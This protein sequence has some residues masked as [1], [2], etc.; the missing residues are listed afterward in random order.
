MIPPAV[1]TAPPR[2]RWLALARLFWVFLALAVLAIWLAALPGFYERV[3]TLTVEPFRLGERVIFDN[4]TAQAQ[5][6]QRSLSLSQTAL[7]DIGFSF[8]QIAVYILLAALIL[9]RAAN[10]FGW[11]SA[12]VLMLM[13][14]TSMTQAVGVSPPFPGALLLM[15]SPTYIVWPLWIAWLAL[16][17]NGRLV[18]RQAF[19]PFWIAVVA[20][21]GLQV[22]NVL[23]IAGFLPPRIDTL[24]ATAGPLVTLPVFGFVLLSQVYRY[25]LVSTPVE[26]QQTKWFLFGVGLFCGVLVVFA[27]TPRSFQSSVVV[28]DLLN[29]VFLLF[30][31]SVAIAILRYRLFDIDLIIRRT[32]TYAVLAAL[33]ALVY[34]GS[35]ILLQQ[36][37]ALV[38]GQRSEVITVLSTL[39]IAALFVP[40]RRRIQDIMDRRFN[41]QRYNAQQVLQDF[42]RTV[43]DETNLDR[44]TG[45]LLQVV[46]ETMQPRSSSLWLRDLTRM[47]RAK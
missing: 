25:L 29:V 28:Q 1:E 32:L 19:W 14:V 35:V 31:I 6:L 12:L 2:P 9:W 47:R 8:F 30:P 44:L 36:L 3:S 39:A 4:A 34:F 7:Y 46:D 18:P 17:P 16:F 40:L 24:S 37:F 42:T 43:R 13:S 20:F 5:A 15:E 41:R 26:R 33:L 27:M 10:G 22:A 11:F 38:S 23:A 45:H 21:F